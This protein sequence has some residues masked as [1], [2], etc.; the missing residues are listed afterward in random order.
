MEIA[1]VFQD[2][3][4]R[5]EEDSDEPFDSTVQKIITDPHEQS[6]SSKSS[7]SV[8]QKVEYDTSQFFFAVYKHHPC[9]VVIG[10]G[11]TSS[12][13]SQSFVNRSDFTV[14]STLHSARSVDKY[15]LPVLGE[16]HFML[17]FDNLNLPITALVIEK[18]DCDILAGIPFCKANDI[19]VHLKAETITIGSTVNIPYGFKDSSSHANIRRIDSILLRNDIE[20]V[21]MPGDYEEFKCKDLQ[22]FDGEVAIEPHSSFS[23]SKS[24]VDLIIFRVIEGTL[25]T[26]NLKGEP[27][28]IRKPQHTA[29]I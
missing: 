11:A 15:S 20:K 4:D 1:K 22:Q 27:V 6:N 25:R 7:S 2:T 13:A 5:T 23:K 17:H 19:H 8:V 18:L 29:Q 3:V 28:Q 16:V 14:K 9:H 10:T 26:P 12:V 21:V 24:W